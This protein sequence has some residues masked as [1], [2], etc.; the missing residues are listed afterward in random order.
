MKYRKYEPLIGIPAIAAFAHPCASYRVKHD[1]M[2]VGDRAMQ[3]AIAEGG[4]KR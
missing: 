2:D 3:G 1:Y 4:W